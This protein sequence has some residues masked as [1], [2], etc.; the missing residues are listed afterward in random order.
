MEHCPWIGDR[1]ADGIEGQK[2]LLFGFSHYGAYDDGHDD[3]DFTNYVI[4]RWAL[5][6][7]IPF[8]N[9]LAGYFGFTDAA[10]FYPLVA[11]ANTLPYSVGDE[12]NMFTDGDAA[13]LRLVEAR[14][15]RLVLEVD[16]DKVIVF[17]AKGWRLFPAYDDRSEDGILEVGG[18][19]PINFGGYSRKAGGYSLAYGLR[20]PMMA[21]WQMM[22]DS[23]R[24]ILR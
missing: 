20:H 24:A 23:V 22:H 19:K 5:T 9:T 4:K 3:S 17:S 14:V 1:F 11:F 18:R 2:F 21:P 13:S 16:P 12:D 8:F 10:A 6:G 7:E 15:K